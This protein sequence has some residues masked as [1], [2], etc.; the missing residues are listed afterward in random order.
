[1]STG[2]FLPDVLTIDGKCVQTPSCWGTNL[3]TNGDFSNGTTG[4]DADAGSTRETGGLLNVTCSG[5][6]VFSTGYC[7]FSPAVVPTTGHKIYAKLCVRVTNGVANRIIFN[8]AGKKGVRSFSPTINSPVENQW[9]YASGIASDF[10]GLTGE[11]L[12]VYVSH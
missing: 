4:W 8:F 1:M 5:P 3:V 9:Y 11:N 6:F 2:G 10:S 12:R 7:W